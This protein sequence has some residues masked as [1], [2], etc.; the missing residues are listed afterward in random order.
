VQN[1]YNQQLQIQNNT[2]TTN[3]N[4]IEWCKGFISQRVVKFIIDLGIS[5]DRAIDLSIEI[6]NELN[7]GFCNIV[8]KTRCENRIKN[9]ET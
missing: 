3:I 8:W 7:N 5:N 9:E 4:F 2:N 6:T 1:L